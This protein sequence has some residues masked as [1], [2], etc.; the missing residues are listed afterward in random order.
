M[1]SRILITALIV[2]ELLTMSAYGQSPECVLDDAK[3]GETIKIHA[4]LFNA[5]YPMFIRPKACPGKAVI[6]IYGNN[7][8]LGKAMLPIKRDDAFLEFE[9]LEREEQPDTAATTCLHCPKYKITADF[10]GKLE[11]VPYAGWKK[12]P[13]TG[14]LVSHEGFGSATFVSRYRLILIGVSNVEAVVREIV[15]TPQ[16]SK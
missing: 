7:Q 11:I 13:K 12:D 1:I 8:L 5:A 16:E 4:E 3:N 15:Q 2:L 14:K 9:R 10:E 6:V